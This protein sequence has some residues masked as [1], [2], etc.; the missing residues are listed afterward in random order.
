MEII[1]KIQRI[2]NKIFGNIENVIRT[3][4]KVFFAVCIIGAIVYLVLTMFMFQ[5]EDYVG[6]VVPVLLVSSLLS[7]PMYAFGEMVAQLKQIN[8]KMK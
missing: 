1:N 8:A 2:L 5:L 4:A 3:V 6:I 7:F